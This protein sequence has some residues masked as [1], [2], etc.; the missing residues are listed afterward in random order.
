[1]VPLHI[2]EPPPEAEQRSRLGLAKIANEIKERQ[3]HQ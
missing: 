1:M 2:M 3:K